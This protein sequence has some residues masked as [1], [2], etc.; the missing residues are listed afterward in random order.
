M[1]QAEIR[2]LKLRFTGSY[3]N[4]ELLIHRLPNG[5]MVFTLDG[6]LA[7]NVKS[8][9]PMPEI[10]TVIPAGEVLCVVNETE[11][12]MPFHSTVV[13][14]NANVG[15]DIARFAAGPTATFLVMTKLPPK[16]KFEVPEGFTALY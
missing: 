14:S 15:E 1:N 6:E 3:S 11:I 5:L 10:G 8:V 7:K 13:D 16:T 9:S 2:A 12:Y 4:G